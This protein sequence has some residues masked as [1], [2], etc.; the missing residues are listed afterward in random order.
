MP[1]FPSFSSS[2]LVSTVES[3]TSRPTSSEPGDITTFLSSTVTPP[4]TTGS[5]TGFVYVDYEDYDE[6]SSYDNPPVP[7]G[8]RDITKM[9]TSSAATTTG[10]EVET[11]LPRLISR[12]T[13]TPIPTV[14]FTLPSVPSEGP[15]VVPVKLSTLPESSTAVSVGTDDIAATSPTNT[16]LGGTRPQAQTGPSATSSPPSFYTLPMKDNNSVDEVSYRIVGLDGDNPKGQ[17]SYFVPRMPPVRERTQNKRIQQL[18][19]EK[20]RRDVPRR[21]SRTREGRTGQRL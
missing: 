2:A 21:P 6:Y 12:K 18:L 3:M 16:T 19:N 14:P 15:T 8:A 7:S 11:A 9:A 1:P 5:S 4:P 20:R 17:Q 13:T 10:H